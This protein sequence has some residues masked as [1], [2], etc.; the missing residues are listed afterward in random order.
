[1][2]KIERVVIAKFASGVIRITNANLGNFTAENVR[3]VDRAVH[4]PFK[5]DLG[6]TTSI[7]VLALIGIFIPLRSKPR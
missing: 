6:I 4:P 5:S 7:Y 3:P 1:M 2:A